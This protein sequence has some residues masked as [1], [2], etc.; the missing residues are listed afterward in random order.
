[1]LALLISISLTDLGEI[2][3]FLLLVLVSVYGSSSV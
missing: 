2:R 1:M 3:E